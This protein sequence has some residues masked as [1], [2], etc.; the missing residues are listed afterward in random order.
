MTDVRNPRMLMLMVGAAFAAGLGAIAS[1]LF[2]HTI[3]QSQPRT[4][5]ES[6]A[7]RLGETLT[8]A[9]WGVVAACSLAPVAVVETVKFV[10]SRQASSMTS[11]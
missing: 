3:L 5:A 2:L 4:I 6:A 8:L 9:D 10:A 11:I 7:Y 1:L